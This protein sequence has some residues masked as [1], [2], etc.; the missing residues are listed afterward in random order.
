MNYLKI[1]GFIF[2]LCYAFKIIDLASATF[3]MVVT[4][5]AW[6]VTYA[7]HVHIKTLEVKMVVADDENDCNTKINNERT[8]L[9][10]IKPEVRSK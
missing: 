1:T 2:L 4:L 10:V 5:W 6:A 8:K 7:P 3:Y 9:T